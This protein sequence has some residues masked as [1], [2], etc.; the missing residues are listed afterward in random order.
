MV[1]DLLVGTS[2]IVGD[3]GCKKNGIRREL[4]VVKD[5]GHGE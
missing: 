3:G 5:R 1:A 4:Q 2:L